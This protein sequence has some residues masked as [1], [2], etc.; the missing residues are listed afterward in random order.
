M[1]VKIEN[2]C[3]GCTS[4]GLYCMGSSCPNRRVERYYCDRCGAECSADNGDFGF[5]DLCEDCYEVLSLL[6]SEVEGE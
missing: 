5:D 3:V 6:E 4:M 2:E 1:S